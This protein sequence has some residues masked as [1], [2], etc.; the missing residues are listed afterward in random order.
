M[1]RLLRRTTLA[2]DRGT[3][4][5]QRQA[6]GQPTGAGDVTGLRADGIDAAEDHIVI[7]LGRYRIA[8]DQSLQHMGAQVDG[9]HIGEA[10]LALAGRAAQGIDNIG[11]G[12][13]S[14]LEG[15]ARPKPGL[16]AEY[17]GGYAGLVGGAVTP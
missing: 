2:V 15:G 13:G 6:G 8:L 10:A 17:I 14:F 11:L 7:L 4:H 3:R 12:H 5:I 16:I 9:M 1:Q